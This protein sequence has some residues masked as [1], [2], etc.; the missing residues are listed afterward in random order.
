MTDAPFV[1]HAIV[2]TEHSRPTSIMQA[3]IYGV[4][5]IKRISLD[6]TQDEHTFVEQARD[7]LKAKHERWRTDRCEGRL[8]AFGKPTALVVNYAPDRAIRYDLAGNEIE[9]LN[10]PLELGYAAITIAR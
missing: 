6:T 1:P 5:N 10:Q 7:G 2:E 9:R 4:A 8:P 3:G